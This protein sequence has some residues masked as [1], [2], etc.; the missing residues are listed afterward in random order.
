MKDI[1]E[2]KKWTNGSNRQGLTKQWLLRLNAEPVLLS[3][4]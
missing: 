3:V 2:M 1:S 4:L